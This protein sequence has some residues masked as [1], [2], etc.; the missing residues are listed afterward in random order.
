MGSAFY[1]GQCSLV[2]VPGPV[3]IEGDVLQ[4]AGRMFPDGVIS[5]SSNVCSLRRPLRYGFRA[6]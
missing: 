2:Y 3:F 5:G 6:A 4:N 1:P